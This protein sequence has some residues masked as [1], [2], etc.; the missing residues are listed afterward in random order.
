KD[1]FL[2]WCWYALLIPYLS[3][4]P[5]ETVS[6]YLVYLSPVFC[7]F[8]SLFF[9]EILPQKISK[10]WTGFYLNGTRCLMIIFIVL[11]LLAIHLR[12]SKTVLLQ[13][14]WS[15]DS[16]KI[17]HLIDDDLRQRD[18]EGKVELCISG[19]TDIPYKE[20]WQP[21]FLRSFD[22]EAF[23][24]FKMIL[25]SV[26]QQHGQ[27]VVNGPCPEGVR[28]YHFDGVTVVGQEGNFIEPFY[29]NFQKG[30]KAWQEHDF[31]KAKVFLA[32]AVEQKPFL[33]KTLTNLFPF[34]GLQ[35]DQKKALLGEMV[36]SFPDR[37]YDDDHKIHQIDTLI[38]TEARDYASALVILAYLNH[39][40]GHRN[41][42]QPQLAEAFTF[43]SLQKLTHYLQIKK[44]LFAEG[45]A[46]LQKFVEEN[47][48]LR[49]AF[50]P[51]DPMVKIETYHG[52]NLFYQPEVD[53]Y[54]GLSQPEGDL[55]LFAFKAGYYQQGFSA[56]HKKE[57]RDRILASEPA[58]S[59]EWEYQGFKVLAQGDRHY[60]F[61][62]ST[63][64]TLFSSRSVREVQSVIDQWSQMKSGSWD[65]QRNAINLWREKYASQ[66]SIQDLQYK[67]YFLRIPVGVVKIKMESARDQ[68]RDVYKV[69]GQLSPLPWMRA[70]TL[71]NLGLHL[72]SLID[73]K[74]LLPLQ[75][76]QTDFHS[77]KKGKIR[78]TIKYHHDQLM[79][80]KGDQSDDI[81][82]DTRD[83]LSLLV[84]FMHQDYDQQSL[85]KT[86]L[87]INKKIYLVVGRTIFSKGEGAGLKLQISRLGKDYSLQK[88]FPV[89]MTL[90]KAAGKY[91]PVEI[92]VPSQGLVF[93][94]GPQ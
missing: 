21:G 50:S 75:F 30:L 86:T 16:I 31:S 84:W 85:F 57:I 93:K 27:V 64:R 51:Q 24:S 29:Q 94:G 39:Q 90:L 61:S 49:P 78:K 8:F 59:S 54:F 19:I 45:G 58:V 92:E 73:Q 26:T 15:Y 10:R 83:F 41:F 7:L 43:V 68:N 82:D 71:H 67:F 34:Y 40:A 5:N 53:Y 89:N 2:F 14:H 72:E 77:L 44:E 9:F 37:Y 81:E 52:F 12:S 79:M 80:L 17:A 74:S 48:D 4:H 46:G 1:L 60:A 3:R 47:K 18:D 62:P 70:M 66:D 87:N 42:V 28:T 76:K 11:N 65:G 32:Q 56:K 35:P 22:F 36:S 55:D 13:Y 33:I 6:K 20:K 25:A 69:S 88:T 23:D 63:Q 91:V 38:G